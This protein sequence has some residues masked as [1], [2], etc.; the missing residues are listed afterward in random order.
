MVYADYEYYTDTYLGTA[1][2][3]P[4]FQRMALRASSFLDYYTQ[5]RA[6][7]HADMEA[8]KMA[9]CA[10]AEQYKIIET[11]QQ[12][13]NKSVES[14]LEAVATDGGEV[15]SET[16]GSWSQSFMSGGESAISAAN[17]TEAYKHELANIA[18]FYLANTGLLYRG[19]CCR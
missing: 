1:I 10:L 19:G 15:K 8:V 4:D 9:C 11:S 5:G 6:P 3:E 14:A 18:K 2:N 12:I 13:A 16:V 17:A 7:K